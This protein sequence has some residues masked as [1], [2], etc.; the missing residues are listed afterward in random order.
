MPPNAAKGPSTEPSAAKTKSKP[1][2]AYVLKRKT[3]KGGLGQWVP[4]LSLEVLLCAFLYTR[5]EESKTPFPDWWGLW[6]GIRGVLVGHV[7]VFT[8][9]FVRKSYL[10]G[11][12]KNIQ[13]SEPD[14]DW[15]TELIGHGTR[16]EAFFMLVPYLSITWMFKLMPESYYD[17]ETPVNPVHVFLQFAVYDFIT[18]VVHRVQHKVETVYVTHKDHH[19]FINPHL[20]NAYSGSVQ[21]TTL[22]ILIPLYSTVLVLNAL[23]IPISQQDYA[24]FGMLYAN[25][26][27]LIHSEYSNPWDGLFEAIGIGTARDHNVHHSQLRYNFGHFFMWWD[28]MFG[29]YLC[30]TKVK[31]NRTYIST[32]A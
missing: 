3:K 19:A 8:Y 18:Y 7:V 1:A 32:D 27:M 6:L 15:S 5:M 24:W 10:H 13:R 30:H 4:L 29:T 25:Y 23:Q 26:F 14:F 20:F 12:E 28:Q 11:Q 9:H 16:P 31:R 21:D 22:L 17:L 2:K